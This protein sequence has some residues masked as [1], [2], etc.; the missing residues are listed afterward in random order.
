MR[1]PRKFTPDQR[2]QNWERIGA[3]ESPAAIARSTAQSERGAL[4]QV[5]GRRV[6]RPARTRSPRCLSVEER[7]E[8]RMSHRVD[9]RHIDP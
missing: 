4:A 9:S 7:E 6:R 1:P 8:L 3:S 2:H 5:G